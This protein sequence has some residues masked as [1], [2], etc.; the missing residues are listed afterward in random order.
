M[1]GWINLS[2]VLIKGSLFGQSN[3]VSH[4]TN[5]GIGASGWFPFQR[6]KTVAAIAILHS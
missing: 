1:K 2:Y 6:A 3:A 5:G 4:Y